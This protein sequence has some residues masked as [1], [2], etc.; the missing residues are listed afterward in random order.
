MLDDNE[1]EKIMNGYTKPQD[2]AS[3]LVDAALVSGGKD[4]VTVIIS[5]IRE[6]EGIMGKIKWLIK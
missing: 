2:M 3:K 6:I 4:N 1:I 5:T